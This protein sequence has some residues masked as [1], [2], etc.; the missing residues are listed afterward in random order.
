MK[1]LVIVVAYNEE[2]R[3]GGVVKA[4]LKHGNVVVID[5]GSS[6]ATAAEGKGAG[7]EVLSHPRNMG[8]GAAM[9]TGMRHALSKGYD[10]CVIMSG[11]GQCRPEFVPKMFKAL[12]QN[13]VCLISRFLGDVSNMPR[14]RYFGNRLFTGL[15]RIATGRKVSDASCGYRGLK[16]EFIESLPLDRMSDDYRF[17]VQMLIRI[18]RGDWKYEELPMPAFYDEQKRTKMRI[19][20]DWPLMVSPILR[21]MVRIRGWRTR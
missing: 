13:D 1:R 8:V 11:D 5:D 21:E 4:V 2:G 14:E 16:N 19:W 7:A 17:E 10:E 15:M 9:K 20:R 18:L 6:D 12:E 3:V